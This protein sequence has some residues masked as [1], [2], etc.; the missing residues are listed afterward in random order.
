MRRTTLIFLSYF[1][2]FALLFLQF[3]LNHALPGN[4]DTWLVISLSNQ[5]LLAFQK[6]FGLTAGTAMFPVDN[7]FAYGESSPLCALLFLI[8][9]GLMGG[10][11]LWGYYLHLTLVFSLTALA[12]YRFAELFTGPSWGALFAG[13]AFTC[14][15]MT[16]AHIDDPI[17]YAYF[18]PLTAARILILAM[19][20]HK[21][22]KA[23][24]AFAVGGLEIYYS[25]YVFIYQTLLFGI[26]LFYHY[27]KHAEKL[28]LR[29]L[30]ENSLL[31]LAIA[32]P[33]LL[34][35]L[36]SLLFRHV[37]NPFGLLYTARMTSLMPFD[38]I[39]ALPEN[40]LYG[41][42][43]DLP[44]NWGFVRH[45]NFIG[46]L[47]MLMGFYG[48]FKGNRHRMLFILCGLCGF[49][50]A[51]GPNIMVTPDS[52]IPAPLYPFYTR[53]PILAYLRVTSRAYFLVLLVFAVC[54]G[55]T[56][57]R[58]LEAARKKSPFLAAG[59][60]AAVFGI[61]ALEQ[62]PMPFKQWPV[63]HFISIPDDYR[64]FTKDK[65]GEIFLDLPTDF[66]MEFNNW[67]DALFSDPSRFI[68]KKQNDTQL[69][70]SELSMFTSSWDNLFQYNREIIYMFWQTYHR[71]STVNGLN[72]YFTTPRM[73][74][75][76]WTKELPGSIAVEKIKA[77]G[78]TALVY[79][80]N[81]ELTA[82]PLKLNMLE[83]SP[84]LIK[85]FEGSSIVVFRFRN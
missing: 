26:I 53:V 68:Y 28:T 10:S 74:Y 55:L 58:L 35:Y 18:I 29:K 71:Q 72:G 9:K 75:Q 59:T 63:E 4:C 12:V 51:L 23:V 69:E 73:I 61:H 48:M 33:Y 54:A 56:L 36:H 64:L 32:A 34:F 76:R 82:D 19:R 31:Y 60:L 6:L 40:L 38:F 41:N 45:R 52:S 39:A 50:F 37:V 22:G 20:E 67:D 78:V 49:I 24:W 84:L 13:F 2:F 11:D 16:F 77:F 7:V 5:Y 15:N 1:V 3:P 66:N 25:L 57:D 17:I 42:L 62:I 46:I 83:Q 80:K 85:I 21:H 47:L 8:S 79:H 65:Q 27:K 70:V 14:C 44:Q 81:M 30:L 43:L